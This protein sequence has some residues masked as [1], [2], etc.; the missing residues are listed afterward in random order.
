[1]GKLDD[2]QLAQ[3][4]RSALCLSASGGHDVCL[5]MLIATTLFDTEAYGAALLAAAR[6]GEAALVNVLLEKKAPLECVDSNDDTAFTLA[7]DEAYFEVVE[8]LIKAG[9]ERRLWFTLNF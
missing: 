8:V 9:A 7:C 1:M 5:D 3:L 2:E 6:G 4:G